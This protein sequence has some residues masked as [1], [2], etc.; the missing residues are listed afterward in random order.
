MNVDAC[1]TAQN[2]LD[3]FINETKTAMNTQ[4]STM[5]G[6]IG[7]D[8]MAPA[9]N[10]YKADFDQLNQNMVQLLDQFTQLSQGFRN[11]ITQWVDT[12]ANMG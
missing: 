10:Q 11:E 3:Q 2:K 8:W 12:G 1:N 6:L 9:A 4:K 5:D 7:T